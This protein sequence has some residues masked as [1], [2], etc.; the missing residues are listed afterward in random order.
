MILFAVLCIR[1]I[2][3][4]VP[5]EVAFIEIRFGFWFCFVS[6]VL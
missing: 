1:I 6:V 3:I 4:N 5:R 2:Q